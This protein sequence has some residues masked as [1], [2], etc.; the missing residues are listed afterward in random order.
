MLNAGLDE[1]QPGIK[2]TRRD[3]NN[4]RY[5]DDITLMAEIEEE[6]KRLLMGLKEDS[7]CLHFSYSIV[8]YFLTIY[9]GFYFINKIYFILNFKLSH[10]CCFFCHG[11]FSFILPLLYCYI[12]YYS[13]VHIL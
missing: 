11:H 12:I 2:I 6:L 10:A 9:F 3:I 1:S 7:V 8:S 13:Q 5:T 4:L